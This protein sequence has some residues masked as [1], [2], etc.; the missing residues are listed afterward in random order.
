[1]RNLLVQQQ[2]WDRSA[3]STVTV[4]NE[5]KQS[6]CSTCKGTQLCAF[7]GLNEEDN[8]LL[9]ASRQLRIYSK[10]LTVYSQGE[11]VEGIFIV[12]SGLLKLSY[13]VSDGSTA[14]VDIAGPGRI[15]CLRDV[16]TGGK[17]GACCKVL[18]PCELEFIRKDRF[19]ELLNR[20]PHLCLKLLTVVSLDAHAFFSQ[21]CSTATR[22]PAVEH[23][24]STLK[25][26]AQTYGYKTKRGL[27]IRLSLKISDIGEMI[28]CSR[29]WTAKLL[30][31]LE[32][33]DLIWR[34]GGWITVIRK[35]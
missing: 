31:E 30:G 3:S 5:D 17:T 32:K 27:C 28:S 21:L 6:S 19:L 12:R 7:F 24:L 20:I 35:A 4:S 22:V 10:G 11:Q 15:I 16:L 8:A 1:M 13:A 9:A 25:V 34:H 14:T 26:I 2:E 29:Q 33:Q 23:L 18:Q